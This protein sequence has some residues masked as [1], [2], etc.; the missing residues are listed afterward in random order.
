MIESRG[1]LNAYKIHISRRHKVEN[2]ND[3]DNE[4]EHEY[5]EIDLNI[6]Y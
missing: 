4:M 2:G 3:Y 5:I 1:S 6:F